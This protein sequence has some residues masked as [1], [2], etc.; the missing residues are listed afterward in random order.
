MDAARGSSFAADQ[1]EGPQRGS[2]RPIPPLVS[3]IQ[4]ATTNVGTSA[5]GGLT[6]NFLA[7]SPQVIVC[8]KL[9]GFGFRV[10]GANPLA[11]PSDQNGFVPGAKWAETEVLAN[12]GALVALGALAPLT[13]EVRF[14]WHTNLAGQMRD[15]TAG[16]ICTS[17]GK[18]PVELERFRQHGEAETSYPRL[19]TE[20][21]EFVWIERPTLGEFVGMPRPLHGLR[22]CTRLKL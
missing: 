1:D 11:H 19:V 16:H 22:R 4:V 15:H 6:P 7:L 10:E 3:E 12:L 5:Q 13:I 17:I 8:G 9:K 2:G 20:Q 21:F 18:S 14:G